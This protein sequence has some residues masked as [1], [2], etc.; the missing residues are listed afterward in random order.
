MFDKAYELWQLLAEWWESTE[1]EM[2]SSNPD[3][4][5]DRRY[6]WGRHRDKVK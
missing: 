5:Q 6:E 3:F 2:P 1:A 4:D